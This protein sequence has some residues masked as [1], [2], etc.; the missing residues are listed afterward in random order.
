MS[1]LRFTPTLLLLAA[2]SAA[3]ACGGACPMGDGQTLTAAGIA[4][5]LAWVGGKLGLFG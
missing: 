2:P 5:G 3:W 4:T 1:L